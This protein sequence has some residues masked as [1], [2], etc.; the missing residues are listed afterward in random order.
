MEHDLTHQMECFENWWD[1]FTYPSVKEPTENVWKKKNSLS[2]TLKVEQSDFFT[3]SCEVGNSTTSPTSVSALLCSSFFMRKRCPVQIKTTLIAASMLQTLLFISLQQHPV[4]VP[5][6]P[7]SYLPPPF[8]YRTLIGLVI[9]HQA[10]KTTP[11]KAFQNGF[12]R[13]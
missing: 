5:P 11:K 7:D 10:K 6:K 12:T 2:D 4:F 9:F 13:I 3:A 1:H 8:I